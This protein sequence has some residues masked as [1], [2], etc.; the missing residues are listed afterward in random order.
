MS[1]VPAGINS[2]ADDSCIRNHFFLDVFEECDRACSEL[3]TS[4]GSLP[5]F[6]TDRVGGIDQG[7]RL[8]VSASSVRHRLSE[9][10]SSSWRRWTA[11]CFRCKRIL[12]NVM[13]I[14][15]LKHNLT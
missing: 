4:P 11:R 5:V 10:K 14:L 12:S 3:G 2:V 7:L 8:L 6:G 13:R 15:Q 9:A 1:T